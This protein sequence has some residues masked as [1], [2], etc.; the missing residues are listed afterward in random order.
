MKP[1]E[2]SSKSG[3]VM[4]TGLQEITKENARIQKR[5]GKISSS[6]N[7]G[8]VK[9][10]ET[11]DGSVNASEERALKTKHANPDSDSRVLA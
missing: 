8:I 6:H 5:T 9:K 3:R 4:P 1:G 11:L 2:N 7:R 10:L